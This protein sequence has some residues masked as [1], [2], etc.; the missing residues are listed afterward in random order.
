MAPIPEQRSCR[1]LLASKAADCGDGLR[2]YRVRAHARSCARIAFC[3][4]PEDRKFKGQFSP[5]RLFS[6]L[7]AAR[8][9]GSVHSQTA[10]PARPAPPF[11]GADRP[12]ALEAVGLTVSLANGAPPAGADGASGGPAALEAVGLAVSVVN[13]APPVGADGG[14]KNSGSFLPLWG[15]RPRWC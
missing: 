8:Y 5:R 2:C 13:G 15:A 3:Q 14:L 11:H 4:S 7:Y 6:A 10:A 12:A 1:P 9:A